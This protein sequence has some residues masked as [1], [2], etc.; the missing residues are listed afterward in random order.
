[1]FLVYKAHWDVK[2]IRLDSNFLEREGE[3]LRF[4]DLTLTRGRPRAPPPVHSKRI[5]RV[6]V[7]GGHAL[8]CEEPGQ[9]AKAGNRLERHRELDADWKRG[10]TA[11]LQPGAQR[12]R[13]RGVSANQEI[14]KA[15]RPQLLKASEERRARVNPQREG[16][17][18]IRRGLQ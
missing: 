16:K 8:L 14:V 18:Q 6:Q 5:R 2:N 12:R 7:H 3:S 9:S 17:V 15:S 10:V 1:V 11:G 13:L 4:I